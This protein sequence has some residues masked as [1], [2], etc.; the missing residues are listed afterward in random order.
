[1][2]KTYGKLQHH[3]PF[4]ST[5]T[6]LGYEIAEEITEGGRVDCTISVPREDD[7]SINT[8]E[9]VDLEIKHI[10]S[11]HIKLDYLPDYLQSTVPRHVDR[12]SFQIH[13]VKAS[14]GSVIMEFDKGNEKS[15]VV[16]KEVP[17]ENRYDG[18]ASREILE[19]ITA[20]VLQTLGYDTETNVYRS[21]RETSTTTEVDI[22]AENPQ[23]NFSIYVSCKNWDSKVGRQTV[24]EEVGRI[25]N[26]QKVP[27]L[28]VLVVED[29]TEDA[30]KA[31]ESN[32]FLAIILGEQANEKNADDI[33]A[34]VRLQ[35]TE[36]LLAIAP[37]SV[38]QIAQKA[39]ELAQQLSGL[40]DDIRH[41]DVDRTS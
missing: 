19:S 11:E 23:Q 21:N 27:Q 20:D 32:G 37:T 4:I 22:W 38:E 17:S 29:L 16:T 33:Y 26:L 1:M 41:I 2:S 31:L 28:R 25:M 7:E 39:D 8:A 35:F 6:P 24:D 14:Y 5:K 34:E 30:E 18:P 40:S 9:R 3:Q 10:D 12:I 36:T 13:N 15:T